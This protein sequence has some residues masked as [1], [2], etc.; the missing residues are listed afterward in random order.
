MNMA[1]EEWCA[2]IEENG[3]IH[4]FEIVN[5][6]TKVK[7]LGVFNPKETLQDISSGDEVGIGQKILTRIEPRLPELIEGMLRR[8][9]TISGKDAGQFITKLGIGP[10]DTVLE[11]GLGSAGSALHIARVLGNSGHHITVEPRFE[12]AEV[13][14]E[15]L[16][17][18]SSLFPE[19]PK[20]THLSG[21]VEDVG[22][23]ISSASQSGLDAVIL[24]MPEHSNSM[25]TCYPLMN[26]G[27]RIA[28]YAPTTIQLEAA[29][30]T[31]EELG[32]KV[33]W[34]GEIIE[35][36]WTRASKGGIKPGKADFGHTAFL[37]FAKK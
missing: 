28:C 18:A 10:G 3:R 6:K 9:Q 19:F 8:A 35:R 30:D 25:R 4:I 17:R 16:R 5:E 14:L 11:A 13:G 27:A 32:L 20:H 15:N 23:Q 29:W 33:E 12:H 1:S 34:A 22:E 24:D 37:L 36:P 26:K 21:F 7:G 2:L 31:C